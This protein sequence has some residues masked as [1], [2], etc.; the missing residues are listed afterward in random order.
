MATVQEIKDCVVV[1]A[2]QY[3]DNVRVEALIPYAERQTS[4][5]YG[6]KYCDAVALR[7]CHMIALEERNG[8]GSS[9]SGDGTSGTIKSEKEGDLSRSYGNSAG[10]NNNSGAWGTLPSTTY[11]QMLIEMAQ[12]SFVSIRN[13]FSSDC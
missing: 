2:P 4:S 12:T 1:F 5:C 7:I 3:E 11:G 10:D 13:R 6:D 8:G 9:S